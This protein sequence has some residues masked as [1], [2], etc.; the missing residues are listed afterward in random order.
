MSSA[1]VQ[2]SAKSAVPGMRTLGVIDQIAQATKK[3]HRLSLIAGCIIGGFIPVASYTLV[4]REAVHSPLMWTLVAAALAYSALTVYD[5]A[6]I[7]FKHTVKAIGFVVLLE[8]V[9][10]FSKTAWLALIALVM[11]VAINGFV[12]ACNLIADMRL[13]RRK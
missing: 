7:A 9:M 4:H 12:T 8:G 3:S 2:F 6:R 11:L 5:W 10:T 1:V 13:K